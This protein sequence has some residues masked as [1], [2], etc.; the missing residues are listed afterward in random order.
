MNRIDSLKGF[1]VP[2]GYVLR[3][4]SEKGEVVKTPGEFSGGPYRFA[5]VSTGLIPGWTL[6]SSNLE[7]ETHEPLQVD[8]E[9][10]HIANDIRQ[11]GGDML[12]VGGAVRD[13]YMGSE[14]KD[15][16]IEVYN[17][18]SEELQK[19]LSNYGKVDV[20]G[21]SFG[22]I[23]LT[24][25]NGDYDFSLPRRENKEGEGHRGFVVEPDHTMSAEEATSRRDYTINGLSMTP[26]GKILDFFGGM[27]DL[28]QRRLRHI[29]DKFSEDPLRVLRGMQ[30]AA[31]FDMTMD[32]ATAKLANDIK[33]EYPTIAKERIFTEWQKWALKGKKPSA[34]LKVLRQTGWIDFYPE[35]K[36]LIGVKQEEKWH[37]EGD[38]WE[39][40]LHVVDEAAIIAERDGLQGEDRF[41]LLMAALCHDFGKP[42]TT[43]VENGEYHAPGH[44]QAGVDPTKSFLRSI[45][46]QE[47]VIAKVWPLVSEHMSHLNDIT[48]RAVR[49]LSLRLHP[50][51]VEMLV[52]VIEADH[53]G[54]PPLEKGVPEK[55]KELLFMANQLSLS[56]ERIKP[57]VLGRHLMRLAQEGYLPEEYKTGGLHYSEVLKT[58]FEAQ[59]EGLF[60]DEAGGI[61]YATRLFSAQYQN[62]VSYTSSLST[63]DKNTLIA[64]A[65]ANGMEMEQLWDK[66]E[67]FIR[68][69]I[70]TS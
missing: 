70:E 57:V 17:V 13:R 24:T 61:L 58:L 2:S 43:I 39:H 1:V 66:G 21:A 37:P 31:R 40:T 33:H 63:Q 68:K 42:T 8:Q 48:P 30:F 38:V 29:S 55:A 25:Q 12:F 64:F 52:R 34:G 16:D 4:S 56:E 10:Y 35:I 49:R 20:V 27:K 53:S 32:D 36:E 44:A 69:I 11:L 45:G 62:A 51:N 19:I 26:E 3:I 59:M 7:T 67:D 14:N 9:V 28:Q 22:V 60:E 5:D 15:V 47:T 50:A 54:R 23:K 65:Q 18:P 41:V 6:E 46:V